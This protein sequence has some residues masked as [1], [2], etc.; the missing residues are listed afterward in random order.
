MNGRGP[1]RLPCTLW[2]LPRKTVFPNRVDPEGTVEDGHDNETQT[3]PE[4]KKKRGWTHVPATAC[5]PPPSHQKHP[6]HSKPHDRDIPA[7]LGCDFRRLARWLRRCSLLLYS[8]RSCWLLVF[9]FKNFFGFSHFSINVHFHGDEQLQWFTLHR[10]LNLRRRASR[11]RPTVGLRLVGTALAVQGV[12]GRPP[13]RWV[14]MSM[15][16]PDRG[17]IA[18]TPPSV[19][20]SPGSVPVLRLRQ[21]STRVGK[22]TPRASMRLQSCVPDRP[23]CATARQR[24]TSRASQSV[25][26]RGKPAA[27]VL[28]AI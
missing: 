4:K 23:C 11:D 19:P 2:P 14:R 17:R 3:T 6:A 7:R 10:H 12:G 18:T 21:V 9:N 5:V 28:F 1:N 27:G 13:P 25:A 15:T 20:Q 24:R 8:E 26:N 22:G 16:P